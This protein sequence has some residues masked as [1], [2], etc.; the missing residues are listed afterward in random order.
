MP[1]KPDEQT[2]TESSQFEIGDEVGFKLEKEDFT[3]IIEKQY[4][5]S[6]MV[7]FKSLDPEILD[8]YHNS[9]VVN[10]QNLTMI[11]EGPREKLKKDN[12]DEDTDK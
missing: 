5:N 1:K 11:K 8:K 7:T 2:S 9:T 12:E 10:W 3:G 6:F 4:T